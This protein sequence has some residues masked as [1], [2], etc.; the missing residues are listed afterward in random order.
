[1]HVFLA[2][3]AFVLLCMSVG[4]YILLDGY[5]LGI[6]LLS[7]FDQGKD[8]RLW[9]QDIL[10]S[11]WHGRE[12]WLL[13]AAL[14]MVIAYPAATRMISAYALY[15]VLLLVLGL[16]F[17][18]LLKQP[19]AMSDDRSRMRAF[20][21]SSL[22]SVTALG[23]LL[24][25]VCGGAD[26]NMNAAA[27]A[28]ALPNI[29]VI[30]LVILTLAG[31]CVQLAAAYL[32]GFAE[33]QRR[34]RLMIFARGFAVVNLVLASLLVAYVFYQHYHGL[35]AHHHALLVARVLLLLMV[36]VMILDLVFFR[37]LRGQRRFFP[38]LINLVTLVITGTALGIGIYPQLIPGVISAAGAAASDRA[39][40]VII[41]LCGVLLPFILTYN[42]IQHMFNI[43]PDH[44]TDDRAHNG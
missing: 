36:I 39:L 3:V 13:M 26:L 23:W 44:R 19:E 9:V 4:I 29:P 1:M 35:A 20:G 11:Q 31:V 38:Y 6:G 25:I 10:S 40:I 16:I 15:P 2:T 30:L 32:L 34:R 37:V 41:T 22:V 43:R 8:T 17:R 12:L 14:I 18:Q 27:T 21:L 28:D 24:G 33:A 42:G 7:L 5:E